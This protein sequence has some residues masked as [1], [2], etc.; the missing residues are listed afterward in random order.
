MKMAE[1][2]GWK[3]N[4]S[5]ENCENDSREKNYGENEINEDRVSEKNRER[6]RVKEN[7]SELIF[8]NYV[9]S[10]I[11]K[12]MAWSETSTKLYAANLMGHVIS[13]RRGWF[14][15]RGHDSASATG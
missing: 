13:N 8:L 12:L 5:W 7:G 9:P 15:D 3:K 14:Y 1:G 11:N 2:E 10:K 4:A 6:R